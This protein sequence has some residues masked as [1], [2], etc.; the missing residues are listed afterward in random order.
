M[1][2]APACVSVPDPSLIEPA[3]VVVSVLSAGV[4]GAYAHWRD[5]PDLLAHYSLGNAANAAGL[6]NDIA[7][8]ALSREH[9]NAGVTFVHAAP[10]AVST[11]WGTEL[12]APIRLPLRVLQAVA[13]LRSPA[14]CAEAMLAPVFEAAPGGGGGMR[15]IGPEAQPA[16]KTAVHDEARDTLW[17]HLVGLIDRVLATRAS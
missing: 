11:N 16:A 7:V 1:A 4:H 12:P 17:P 3:P 10:G 6:Y 14:D 8:D 13:P 15:L 5:D 2:P 9:A